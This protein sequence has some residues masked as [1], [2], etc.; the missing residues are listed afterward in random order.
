M[1]GI[2]ICYRR[3]DTAYQ[4]GHIYDQL[5]QHFGEQVFKDIDSI[6]LGDD[7]VRAIEEL[8]GRS[9]VVLVL[10]G[11]DWL[12]S[13]PGT[14]RP[15]LEDPH[16]L[17]RREIELALRNQ[18]I[19]VPIVLG[20]AQMPESDKLPESIRLLAT[21]NGLRVNPAP[22]FHRDMEQ[23]I[24]TLEQ[25]IPLVPQSPEDSF[26]VEGRGPAS[27]G[28][29]GN[30]FLQVLAGLLA[31]DY[32]HEQRQVDGRGL[33]HRVM[34]GWRFG[35]RA[36]DRQ[37]DLQALVQINEE[38]VRGEVKAV[39]VAA[40]PAD[41]PLRHR[42]RAYLTQ[43]VLRVRNQ[44]G[45]SDRLVNVR[46]DVDE[47]LLPFLPTYWP[48]FR[49][50]DRPIPQVDWELVE[51]LGAGGYGEVWKA[52]NPDF[53][54][55][56]PV[57]LKFCLDETVRQKLLGY[58]AH[59]ISQ[60]LAHGNHPGIVPL[61]QAYLKAEPPCLE[62]EFVEGGDLVRQPLAAAGPERIAQVRAWIRQL[63]ETVGHFHL[64][65]PPVVHRDLK[66]ANVLVARSHGGEP[67]LRIADFGIG[68]LVADMEHGAAAG[69]E[70][71]PE[72]KPPT[73]IRSSFTPLYA[74]PQQQRGEPPDPRDDVYS[75]G[76]IW[77]QLLTGNLTTG[78]PRGLQWSRDL[79][80]MGMS[81]DDLALLGACMEERQELRPAHAAELDQRL[82]CVPAPVSGP[83]V[84]RLDE[85]TSPL[86]SPAPEP[87]PS[88]PKLVINPDAACVRV[89]VEEL[90]GAPVVL[91]L[92]GNGPPS[93]AGTIPS[94]SPH[95]ATL[96][97]T[98]SIAAGSG[99]QPVFRPPTPI[100]DDT[101]AG[102]FRTLWLWFA[103]CRG[104]ASLLWACILLFGFVSAAS[105]SMT[106]QGSLT[107]LGLMV[108]LAAA[109]SLVDT[110]LL[111][112]L[113]HR[114]WALLQDVPG[115]TSPGLAVG[116]L[117]VPVFHLFWIF[118]A[119]HGLA[120]T[121]NA[122]LR[123]CQIGQPRASEGLGL[124]VCLLWSVSTAAAALTPV[125]TLFGSIALLLGL[126]NAVLWIL[127][128]HT[129]TYAA[130]ALVAARND[131]VAQPV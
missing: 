84:L 54:G 94:S 33:A 22:H 7:F 39:A 6:A 23:L 14:G 83:G 66:P 97:G 12:A 125:A 91:P 69:A 118:V 52:R 119:F 100:P 109:L 10:I 51:L 32:P 92:G 36:Q 64:L 27:L 98:P 78:A 46:L 128:T 63:A 41:V 85:W 107:S 53:H 120:R 81:A 37:E 60:V 13:D 116:L 76:V 44:F 57:A 106:D 114:S 49:P 95:Q 87:S 29:R 24:Q 102:T 8:I 67:R 30:R 21:R 131:T 18:K 121:M 122:Q 75:L 71:W 93:S 129:L 17:V 86:R 20:Q 1:P 4:A 26:A 40:I 68:R 77:Y 99:A 45:R 5:V 50:G 123:R 103:I 88:G 48:R 42:A 79:S 115:A 3:L 35:T 19:V 43:V 90:P 70:R 34:A 55:I 96:T 126:A 111:L 80:L 82:G 62:Y 73:A 11:D 2:F 65:T 58:E 9:A 25:H 110:V 127:F 16:D 47:D 72:V 15:R 130:A 105:D 113:L 112:I 74:S 59:L 89:S 101:E 104:A 31:Q 38:L 117:F 124:A 61:R 56:P 28:K 108:M